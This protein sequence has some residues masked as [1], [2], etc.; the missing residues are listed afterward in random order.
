M[1]NSPFLLGFDDLERGHDHVAK[2]AG[3]NYP[4]YNIERLPA[5]SGELIRIVLAVAGFSKD[6]LEIV[7]TGNRLT[8][9]GRQENDPS[10]VYLHR[11]IAAR[12]FQR[13]FVLADGMRVQS[14]RL[15]D[16]LLAIELWRP[17]PSRQVSRIEICEDG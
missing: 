7:L 2:P 16:G 5:E 6:Q 1:I 10:R 13:G 8:I 12:Q 14:A 17:E 3:D 15:S 9:Q 4:P 11:G